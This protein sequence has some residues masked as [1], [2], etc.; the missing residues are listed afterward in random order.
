MPHYQ[1]G[2]VDYIKNA[3]G[4]GLSGKTMYETAV[5]RFKYK[6]N[7]SSFRTYIHKIISGKRK[8]IN[9]KHKE[10]TFLDIITKN[11]VYKII[12]LCNDLNCSPKDI[13]QEV[14]EYRANGLELTISNGNVIFNSQVAPKDYKVE[15]LSEK[16][17]VFGV[18]SD[19]HFGSKSVQITALNEFAEIC[20]KE[21]VQH[22]LCPGDVVAGY[23]VYPGQL[24][25]V[26]ATTAEEQEASVVNNLPRG[27]SWYAIGGNHDYAFIKKGG[28]HN[29]LLSIAN[30]IEN[31]HYLGYDEAD[32]PLLDNVSAKLWHPSGGVPYSVSYRLQKGMEQVAFSELT[33]ITKGTKAQPTTR[34]VLCGHL[35]VQVQALFGP[36]FGAVCG[37][38][39]GQTNYLKRKALTPSIGGWIIK[40][41][42]KPDSGFLLNFDAK[43]HLFDEIEDDWKAYDHSV[44]G[45]EAINPILE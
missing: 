19:L 7:L 38:F 3:S 41:D 12:D 45:L 14:K 36:I 29:P 13:Y 34:F 2:L 25:D 24:F 10:K 32:V 31:F 33:N 6:S 16:E 15:Q 40:A 30:Q 5:R 39:E 27:F 42:I 28:G 20:R 23:N 22:I 21:G 26:Y 18:A 37:T 4:K 17:I 1:N 35:H 43:F 44:E 9:K 11:K 8:S